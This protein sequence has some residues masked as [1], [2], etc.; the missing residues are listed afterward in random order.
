MKRNRRNFSPR[1]TAWRGVVGLISTRLFSRWLLF[2]AIASGVFQM[3]AA[4]AM[5]VSFSCLEES[6]APTTP[7]AVN[8]EDTLAL[9]TLQVWAKKEWA[10]LRPLSID[11]K[12]QEA[13]YRLREEEASLLLDFTKAYPGSGWTP[14]I[15]ARLGRHYRN[16]GRYSMALQV[17][18]QA[19]Q[20]T[21]QLTD[22]AG[23]DLAD[24]TLAQ[25]VTLLTQLGQVDKL[26]VALAESAGRPL[27]DDACR[28]LRNRAQSALSAMTAAPQWCYR[29]GSLC[30]GLVG[31]V[32]TGTKEPSRAVAR[33]PSPLQGYSLQQ[34]RELAR[35]LKLSL[36][37]VHWGEV[38]DLVVPSVVHLRDQHYAA[39]VS[40]CGNWYVVLDPTLHEPQRLHRS[41][42]LQEATGYFLVPQDRVPPGWSLLDATDA[43]VVSGRG[44]DAGVNDGE[45]EPTCPFGTGVAGYGGGGGSTGGNGGRCNGSGCTLPTALGV[46]EWY[47]S[48]PFVNLW[49]LDT[50]LRYQPALGPEVAV[51]LMYRQRGGSALFNRWP[52]RQFSY[53][54]SGWWFPWQ[55]GI[56][57]GYRDE[58]GNQDMTGMLPTGS[59]LYY[60]FEG[61]GG[62]TQAH[63]VNRTK[64]E[65]VVDQGT[66]E[67]QAV[68]IWY[69]N[70]ARDE[71]GPVTNLYGDLVRMALK[72]RLDP[73]GRAVTLEYFDNP[74]EPQ[75]TIIHRVVDPDGHALTFYYPTEGDY[76]NRVTRIEDWRFRSVGL[77]Y[78]LD[79]PL[80]LRRIT[81]PEMMKSEITYQNGCGDPIVLNTPY[82]QTSFAHLG[83]RAEHSEYRCITVTRPT[84]ARERYYYEMSDWGGFWNALDPKNA[85]F[86]VPSVTPYDTF[87]TGPDLANNNSYYWDARNFENLSS[88]FKNAPDLNYMTADDCLRA[89]GRNWLVRFGDYSGYSVYQCLNAERAPSPDSSAQVRGQITWYDYPDKPYTVS[90]GSQIQPGVIARVMPDATT[91]YVWYQRNSAGKVWQEIE[92][93]VEGGQAKYR[94]NTFSYAQND[95][96]LLEHRFG[97]SGGDRLVM[98]YGYDPDYPH[99]PVRATNAVGEI[100]AY[101]YDSSQ[102]LS[103][104]LTPAGLLTT[105]I[106]GA[107]G[108]LETAIDLIA[109]TPLRT[110]SYTWLDNY[111]NTHTDARGLTV[112]KTYDKLGR[113]TERSF[114]AAHENWSFAIGTPYP[115]GTGDLQIYEATGYH[116]R[117]TNWTYTTWTADRR[118]ETVIDPAGVVTAYSYCDCG[119]VESVTRAY[120]LPLAETTI[121]GYD[122]QGRLTQV[123]APDSTTVSYD[124][125][126]P[127]RRIRQIDALGTTTLTHDNLGRLTSISSPAGQIQATVYDVEDHPT[128]VTDA[129]G[130]TVA[131]TFDNLGRVLTKTYPDT[132]VEKFLYSAMGLIAYTNQIGKVTLYAY[133]GALRKTAETNANL[134]VIRYQYTPAGD[135]WKLTDGKGQV[136][137]WNYDSEGRVTNKLD[138]V[139]VEILRY[140]YDADSRLTNR[141]SRAKGYT[142]YAY[143]SVGNLTN[144]NYPSGTDP[145]FQFDALRRVTNMV[146]AAGTTAYTY[147]PGGHLLAEDGPWANDTVTYSYHA[148]VGNL[149]TGLSLQQPTGTW[150]VTETPDTAKRLASVVSPAGTF[151]YTYRGAGTLWTNLALPNAAAITNAL[152]SVG[153]LTGT[154]LKT[155]ASV[156]LSKY[157]YQYNLAGQRW[158]MTRPDNSTVTYTY[159]DLGQLKRALGSGGQSTENLGYGYDLAWNLAKLTN[160]ASV[161][162]F[163][164]NGKNELTSVA[165]VTYSYDSNG[166]LS[167]TS[168][169][170]YYAYDADNQLTQAT[171]SGSTRADFVYDGRGRLRKRVEYVWMGSGWYPNGETR[172]VYDGMRVIQ[173]R[174]SSNVPT[175]SYTRG[176][177]LSGSLE[178]AGGIGGLLARSDQYSSGNWGRH[179][180]YFADGNGNVVN[181]VDAAAAHTVWATYRYNP[182]GVSM[183]AV[184]TLASANAYRFS[185]KEWL[186]SPGLYY[187]GYR[188]YDPNLQRWLNRD[189]IGEAGGINLYGFSANDPVCR[190]DLYGL[191]E[192]DVPPPRFP[193]LQSKPSR[194]SMPPLAPSMGRGPLACEGAQG[195]ISGGNAAPPYVALCPEE[196]CKP[197]E[198]DHVRKV[199]TGTEAKLCP[200]TGQQTVDCYKVQRCDEVPRQTGSLTGTPG[201]SFVY[202]FRWITIYSGCPCPEYATW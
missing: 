40:G 56:S 191:A 112:T 138:Q 131:S 63:F 31:D 120:G 72:S 108:Y 195:V 94:T 54:G 50:P 106:Y 20:A 200:C 85:G 9:I 100:T 67:L 172:Y 58:E 176:N 157:L 71:Y 12:Q 95:I 139:N 188:F 199:K 49:L 177:D 132:G 6:V 59:A 15:Q 198:K 2:A 151:S 110:N 53:V 175:V 77:G 68:K 11:P 154:Y 84:G 87:S 69:P 41:A 144:V 14:A 158:Q 3:Q 160:G 185:S 79:Q 184:G 173:E 21:Q 126:L 10:S 121:Y 127:G 134:E 141:W 129:N 18:D 194:P 130:V 148:T 45:D 73:S 169:G 86:A 145:R 16:V 128:S 76:T 155:N 61:P 57:V 107:D 29:C 174:N 165:S 189:P 178:G 163:T 82:G 162:T 147:R 25:Y 181:L 196:Q 102:R 116:D 38:Q 55:G 66:L 60:S 64:M 161:T 23:R 46:L 202:V 39:I 197:D 13:R 133:D 119:A 113:L 22:R 44:Y 70:G 34:L 27:P 103:S 123:T 90:V 8:A 164:V 32:L 115:D 33:L 167:S 51:H 159:D 83:A 124:Y 183:A 125:D 101:T 118:V 187:Y 96:D 179:A 105:N 7:V 28:E 201:W 152:D 47:V 62:T 91:W 88:G 78:D 81:D 48:E 149:R 156:V 150:A 109:G 140:Q 4:S 111:L 122:Q 117:L 135:L 143:D 75:E 137:T 170:R 80:K 114:G 30:V 168:T 99:Q 153:R 171:V 17:W 190:F 97:P 104:V 26:A 35:E 65:R 182:Y 180:C 93:W 74:D 136:T 89:R 166:N 24:W 52:S 193:P 43:S 192:R 92:K 42:I 146:D 142:A 36:V 19:W 1:P 37:P 5:R 98:A 186:A